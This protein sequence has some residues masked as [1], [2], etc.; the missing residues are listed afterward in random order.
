VDVAVHPG[1]EKSLDPTVRFLD[2]LVCDG[3]LPVAIGD[4]VSAV[5]RNLRSRRV[6]DGAAGTDV[7]EIPTE[8]LR[9]AITNA[10]MHRDYST[11]ARGQQVAVDIYRDRIEIV[12]PGG[13]WGARTKD[14]VA[15]GYS[16]ARNENLV[17]LLTWVPMP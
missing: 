10:A 11:F 6:V 15:D 9:E 5:R 13:F 12:S 1:T 17:R 3:P 7:P 4:A 2:R 14:N 16:T 8:V